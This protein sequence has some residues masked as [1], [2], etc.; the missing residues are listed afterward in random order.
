[1]TDDMLKVWITLIWVLSFSQH[2]HDPRSLTGFEEV[3]DKKHGPI[4]RE[5]QHVGALSF[6]VPSQDQMNKTLPDIPTGPFDQG[7]E[8]GSRFMDIK[9][10]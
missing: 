1:M 2:F 6:L 5:N 10:K 7:S 9:V 3:A 4:S 8:H